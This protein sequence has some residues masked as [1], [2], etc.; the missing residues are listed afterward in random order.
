M[1][2]LSSCVSSETYLLSGRSINAILI[3]GGSRAEF[4]VLLCYSI[5][6]EPTEFE[7]AEGKYMY[8]FSSIVIV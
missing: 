6:A 1:G 2:K 5:R 4:A 7:P 8:T 3:C